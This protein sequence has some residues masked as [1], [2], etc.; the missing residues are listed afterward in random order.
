MAESISSNHWDHAVDLLVIGSGAGAMVCALRAH[1]CGGDALLIEK[2]SQYGGSSAMSGGCLWVPNNHLM[3][4]VGIDD[5]P[6]DALA[7]LKETTGGSVSEAR[8]RAYVETA[9]KMAKYLCER[10]QVDLVAM[11]EYP[12]YYPAASGYCA[13]GRALEAKNFDARKLGDEFLRMR[14]AAI[15]TLIM[16]RIFLTIA[17][18]RTL[19]CRGK[20]RIRLVLR[21]FARYFLDLPWRF[22]SKRDRNLAMGN[23]L[24]GGLRRSLMDRDIP[25]WLN[26]PA[27]ELLVEEGRVIGVAAEKNGRTIRIRARKGVVL[28]AGGFESSQAM[29]EKYLPNPTRVEWTCT[30]PDNTGDAIHMGLELGAAT[31]LMAEAWWGPTTVV[32]GED[33]ARMLFIEKSLPGSVLVNRRGE[34][35]VNEA[36]PYVDVVKAIYQ[37]NRPEASTIP[38][39]LIYDANFRRKYPCGPFLPGGHQPDWALPRRVKRDYLKKANTLEGLAKRL[40]IDAEGLKLSVPRLNEHARTGEDTDFQR[41]G[42]VFDRYYGDQQVEPNPCLAPIE[43]P[44][45]YGVEVFPGD[46]GTKGGLL[47]DASA[48][49]LTEAGEPI[50]GLYAIGNCSASVM[51]RSYPGPGS[52]LGPTTTFGLIAARHAMEA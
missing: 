39:Y 24:V 23:A 32:P 42:S 22:K 16:R 10:T 14:E 33:R 36:L 4:D 1:D 50:V 30:N 11:L 15:Q 27:R 44:P 47:T 41:G 7:Y 8:L 46:L 2:S 28:A 9:P 38:C 26:T 37:K 45:F 29:R 35:F 31:D 21:L 43:T 18:G 12:D 34:R 20:G 3:S 25:L 51:G 52:T 5:T 6:D 13:G 17:E 49:V 48:R 40:G 19:F